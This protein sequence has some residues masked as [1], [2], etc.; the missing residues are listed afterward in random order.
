MSQATAT[1]KADIDTFIRA[2]QYDPR[3]LLAVQ[4]DGATQALPP[5]KERSLGAGSVIIATKRQHR[6]SK[7]LSDVAILR[8][9]AGVI[10]PGALIVA[11]VNL[12][13]G[14]PTPIS[15]ARAPI[16][17]STDLPGVQKSR[18][19]VN[20]VA[21]STVQDAVAQMLEAW[22]QNRGEYQIAARSFLTIQSVYSSMQASLD[23]G[24]NAKWADGAASAQL[25]ASTSSETKVLLANYRQIFYT[26]TMDTPALPS[27]VF[28]SSVGEDDLRA[29]ISASHPPAYVRSVDYGRILMIRMETTSS[30]STLE[31]QTSFKQLARDLEVQGHVNGELQA[32]ARQ[33][34]FTV[35]AIGGGVQQAAQ[36]DGT[37]EDLQRLG[38]YIRENATFRRD[39]P[40]AP[41]SYNV[42]F[43][44]D[45]VMATMGFTTDYTETESVLYPNGYVR[46]KH[47]GAYVAKFF[48]NWEEGDAS[49]NFTA[50]SWASGNQ[51]AGYS[52]QVNLP[53]DARNVTLRAEAA[54]GLVWN[55][56][57]EIFSVGLAGPDNKT[58]R[59]KGTTLN[60]SWDNEA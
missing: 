37:A 41:I 27:D 44:K 54:T 21:H 26:V 15:L 49:G 20:Q 18:R 3:Q 38:A 59:A 43:L 35:V 4:P 13:E 24:F 29:V 16:S 8:P 55:P 17:I 50:K 30:K 19:I 32:I 58:Y 22:H 2:L 42:A 51:T 46:L 56:W 12:M 10:Y 47:S 45:N 28:D 39:N 53:G 36:F 6:L 48:V 7:N 34:K 14:Q 11:D 57:A 5:T 33:S 60:R 25:N 40:G 9:T 1:S 31:L 52:H 23:L